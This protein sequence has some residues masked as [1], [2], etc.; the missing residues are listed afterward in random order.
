M[1]EIPTESLA[2]V[3]Q[4]SITCNNQ[5]LGT[6]DVSKLRDE[7]E[8]HRYK[9]IWTKDAHGGPYKKARKMLGV[10]NHQPLTTSLTNYRCISAGQC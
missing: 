7:R 3:P 5:L 8:H 9:Q 2:I 10:V 4:Q 1:S 6:A